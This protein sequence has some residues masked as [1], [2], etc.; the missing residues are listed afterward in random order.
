MN[1]LQDR[2]HRKD[3]YTIASVEPGENAPGALLAGGVFPGSKSES[4]ALS[5]PW[6]SIAS[7][8]RRFS[9]WSRQQTR[10]RPARP[11]VV[12][13][14]NRESR[15]CAA[16]DDLERQPALRIAPRTP[17]IGKP[18]GG[19][20][21]ELG[22]MFLLGASPSTAGPRG[23]FPFDFSGSETWLRT[24][25]PLRRRREWRSAARSSLPGDQGHA[26][27]SRGRSHYRPRNFSRV[28]TWVSAC[29]K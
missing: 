22:N 7:I 25:R 14:A 27:M 16:T 10:P 28:A 26:A 2:R 8:P 9:L 5:S 4:K 12:S 6:R 17:W 18:P 11:T 15:R 1:R 21:G 20:N 29:A 13:K 23:I 3:R 24:K 19:R